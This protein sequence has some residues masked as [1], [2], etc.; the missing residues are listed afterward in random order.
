MEEL[1][2]NPRLLITTMWSAEFQLP[3]NDERLLRISE[4]EALEQV[5]RLRAYRE[6]ILQTQRGLGT[7]GHRAPAEAQDPLDPN[8]RSDGHAVRDISAD[9]P[10]LTGEPE[11][12][13]IELAATQPGAGD[14]PDGFLD[15][16]AVEDAEER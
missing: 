5:M 9:E 3:P 15:G 12:D 7:P 14:W 8:F 2:Q 11:N 10:H 16:L 6:M 13:A 1:Q 4:R